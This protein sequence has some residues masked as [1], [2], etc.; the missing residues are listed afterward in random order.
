MAAQQVADPCTPY[1]GQEAYMRL[2]QQT[3]VQ[4]SY[5]RPPGGA[6]TDDI[7]EATDEIPGTSMFQAQGYCH[8]APQDYQMQLM[9]LEQQNKKRL[10]MAKREQRFH[11]AIRSGCKGIKS[12]EKEELRPIVQLLPAEAELEPN[13]LAETQIEETQVKEEHTADALAE[14]DFDHD[15]LAR[16]ETEPSSPKCSEE[17]LR[18]MNFQ[19]ALLEK[20]NRQRVLMVEA[21][22]TSCA[23]G[24]R[25]ADDWQTKMGDGDD[26]RELDAPSP[27]MQRV[28]DSCLDGPDP[29]DRH[30]VDTYLE[31]EGVLKPTTKAKTRKRQDRE[32]QPVPTQKEN[33]RRLA[34]AQEKILRH[35]PDPFRYSPPPKKPRRSTISDKLRSRMFALLKDKVAPSSAL[36][37]SI[38]ASGKLD[39]YPAKQHARNVASQLEAEH[40]LIYLAGAKGENWP[41]S[42]VTKP[43]RQDR[44]FYYMTGCNEADCHVSYLIE[45]DTLTLWLPPIDTSRRVLFNGRGLTVEE[46]MERYDIDEA[47]Y[48]NPRGSSCHPEWVR[49][50]RRAYPSMLDPYHVSNTAGKIVYFVSDL[51][52]AVNAC[53][54]FKDDHEIGLIRKANK[55]SAAAHTAVL[56][57]IVGFSNEAEVAG[58][59]MNSCIS[60]KAKAQAYHPICG[61]GPNAAVLHYFKNDADFGDRQLMVLDAGA[62]WECYASDVTRSFPLNKKKPGE[63]PSK[64]A[65]EIYDL[66]AEMQDKCIA[67]LGPGQKYINAHWLAHRIAIEGLQK[68]GIL[69][70]DPDEI[71]HAGTILAFFPHG[72]GH[73]MGLEVQDTSRKPLE[74]NCDEDE[75]YSLGAAYSQ[76][77]T[78]IDPFCLEGMHSPQQFGMNRSLCRS[79]CSVSSPALEPGMVVTVEP[80]IYFNPIAFEGYLKDPKQAKFINKDVLAKYV[81]VGGVRIEDD[82]LVTKK[83]YENLT[84][85]PKGDEA[86]EI[87]KKA[88]E[89]TARRERAADEDD[90]EL[91]LRSKKQQ[92]AEFDMPCTPVALLARPG[93]SPQEYRLPDGTL[94]TTPTRYLGTRNDPENG[95]QH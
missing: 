34:Q 10:M 56:E 88:A 41:D 37:I 58:I 13:S 16:N 55:I 95:Y 65:K 22:R 3:M 15:F 5:Q 47:K 50:I 1:G 90:E 4:D 27:L 92:L 87:I 21:E 45:T 67:S 46:A 12:D 26:A 75:I 66:V 74:S 93:D 79:P 25:A 24:H 68:L 83:G 81:P 17:Q 78:S 8:P 35:L 39:K 29:L 53:R 40:G 36:D 49:I 9:L 57:G 23:K 44:Y 33:A 85:A 62:E 89:K 94:I 63:W 60:R 48:T 91:P 19:L 18:N 11:M 64:E 59:W 84:T 61:S 14:L 42:I 70:G 31:S 32:R 72:L 43:F 52:G 73:H 38:R 82:I 28:G 2:M 7:A 51:K 20:L 77:D 69:Q 71:F 80:G 86:L 6:T 30:E 76:A 54:I